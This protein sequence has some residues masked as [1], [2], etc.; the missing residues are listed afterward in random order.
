MFFSCRIKDSPKILSVCGR[1]HRRHFRRQGCQ[2]LVWRRSRERARWPGPKIR[3]RASGSDRAEFL[4]RGKTKGSG[5]VEFHL[6]YK[7]RLKPENLRA[8][9][10]QSG[11]P[12]DPVRDLYCLMPT[13]L[14][15]YV[16]PP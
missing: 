9:L 6:I 2:Y 14:L 4:V 16:A 15:D 7:S 1:G 13:I 8:Y 5:P 12:V 11:R 3:R 10:P